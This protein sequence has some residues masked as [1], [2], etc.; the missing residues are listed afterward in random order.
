[1][2][3]QIESWNN[4]FCVVYIDVVLFYDILRIIN[5]RHF[6]KVGIMVKTI[7][8]FLLI[9][10]LCMQSLAADI[11][12]APISK[13]KLEMTAKIYEPFVK[14]L[15]D[16]TGLSVKARYISDYAEIIR[17]FETGSIDLVY[18]G[19]LPLLEL[20]SQYRNI[21]K[22]VTFL[23][24]DGTPEYTC[25][26]VALD[27]KLLPSLK[28]F[29]GKIALTQP[30]ST[31]GHYNAVHVFDKYGRGNL[32]GIEYYYSGS[33][34]SVALDVI[35]GKAQ[36]G[37]MQT[38]IA[39]SYAYQNLKILAVSEPYPGFTLA[40]NTRTLSRKQIETIRMSLLAFDPVNNP[41]DAKTAQTWHT[42][43][44]YGSTK[45]NEDIFSRMKKE[46]LMYH[47]K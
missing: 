3:T 19:P 37:S 14:W 26:I 8:G 38:S 36:V 2:C 23:S 30:L 18:L 28:N 16:R 25:S 20:E 10:C 17:G 15:S 35:M 27:K 43:I 29:R 31:C 6:I 22:V 46:F 24:D 4:H 5:I 34:T 40:A 44:R 11:I 41:E 32:E 47:K 21:E 9:F 1:M 12:F 13:D 39:A 42:N 7:F 33:H 45:V